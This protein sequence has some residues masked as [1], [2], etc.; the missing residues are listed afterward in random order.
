M[1]IK[2]YMK[3]QIK[4]NCLRFSLLRLLYSA[5]FFYLFEM[6]YDKRQTGT[7]KNET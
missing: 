2:V 5:T 6:Q 3:N 1:Y 7:F 4:N